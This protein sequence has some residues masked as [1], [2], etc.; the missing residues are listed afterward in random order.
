MERERLREAFLDGGLQLA[1]HNDTRII[2]ATHLP[3]ART[4]AH[5]ARTRL[6]A[7][8]LEVG[9]GAARREAP[10]RVLRIGGIDQIIDFVV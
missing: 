10:A 8:A 9:A 4:E 6:G 3:Y 1:I 2:A 5:A 7:L